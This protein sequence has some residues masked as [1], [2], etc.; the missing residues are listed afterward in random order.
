MKTQTLYSPTSIFTIKGSEIIA[1][2][3]TTNSKRRPFSEETINKVWEK[4]KIIDERIKDFAR[5]DEKGTHIGKMNYD[6][7]G[8]FGWTIHHT[9]PLSNGGTDDID[10]LQPRHW[11]NDGKE[12]NNSKTKKIKNKSLEQ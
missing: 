1:K 3:T 2:K 8:E 12:E 7:E 9:K 6:E 5:D 11:K 4:G 10:N